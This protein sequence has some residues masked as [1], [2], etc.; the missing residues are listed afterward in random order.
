MKSDKAKNLIESGTRTTSLSELLS[1][2]QIT[3]VTA[4]LNKPVDSFQ[5][6]KELKAYL[7]QFSGELQQKGVV[8]DYLAYL[9]MA[10]RDN[11]LANQ[12]RLN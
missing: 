1:D 11:I 8:S 10:N 4:I 5:T 2:E 7:K 12:A 3:A 6:T 9:L